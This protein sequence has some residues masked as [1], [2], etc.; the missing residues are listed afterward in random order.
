MSE[1]PSREPIATSLG[2]DGVLVAT[3][4]MA[5]RTMNLFSV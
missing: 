4:D 1:M 2:A 5:G 3:I